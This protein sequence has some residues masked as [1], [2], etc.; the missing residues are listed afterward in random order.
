MKNH[1]DGKVRILH[2]LVLPGF[3]DSVSELDSQSLVKDCTKGIIPASALELFAPLVDSQDAFIPESALVV[4]TQGI[5]PE[6]VPEP[7]SESQAIIPDSLPTSSPKEASQDIAVAESP[8]P[9]QPTKL[10]ATAI[11]ATPTKITVSLSPNKVS[12][13]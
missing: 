9:A 8:P 1:L 4:A 12:A 13:T 5:I 7:T 6:S 2:S 3:L 10:L 11:R